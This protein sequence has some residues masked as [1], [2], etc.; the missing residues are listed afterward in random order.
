MAGI[1]HACGHNLIAIVSLAGALA[2]ANLIKS[3]GLA[4]K[5]VLFGTPAEEGG[6]GKIKLLDAGAYRDNKVNISLITHPGIGPDAA[7]V[8]TAAYS[9]FNV[10]YFGK[11]AHAAARPWDGV[12]ATGISTLCVS[13]F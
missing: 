2:T 4:G 10:E 1:G 9:G 11:E 7:L 13:K 3:E 5:V 6:G 12:G 8:R